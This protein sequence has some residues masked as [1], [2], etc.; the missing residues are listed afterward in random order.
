MYDF[1]VSCNAGLVHTGAEED[2]H[3]PVTCVRKDSSIAGCNAYLA[4]HALELIP[5]FL[6]TCVVAD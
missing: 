5:L 6:S 3:L 4:R 2:L 1:A